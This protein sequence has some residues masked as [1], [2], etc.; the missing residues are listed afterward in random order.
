ME[1]CH[2]RP[3]LRYVPIANW[4]LPDDE[5]TCSEGVQLEGLLGLLAPAVLVLR[6]HYRLVRCGRRQAFEDVRVRVHGSA[7]IFRRRRHCYLLPLLL[8]AAAVRL[9]EG[10]ENVSFEEC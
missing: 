8:G 10:Q 3:S 4:I 5:L 9:K 2:W 6:S 1:P 7:A